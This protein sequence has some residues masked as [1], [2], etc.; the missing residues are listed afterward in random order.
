MPESRSR[1]KGREAHA[2]QTQASQ[3]EAE[4]KRQI[5]LRAYRARRMAGWTFVA[6]AVVV[7]VSH[8]LAH[9]GVWSFASLGV[10]DLVAGYPLALL[11]GVAGAIVLS[12]T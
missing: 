10:M 4:A 11:L 12:K 9:L 8:W 1:K 7:G 3:K 2:R 5:S 6:L